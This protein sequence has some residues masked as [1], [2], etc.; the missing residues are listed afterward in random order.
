M[1]NGIYT[2]ACSSICVIILTD[3]AMDICLSCVPQIKG[4]KVAQ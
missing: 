4:G 3:E 1:G 2:A